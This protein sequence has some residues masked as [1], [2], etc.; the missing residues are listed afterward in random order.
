MTKSLYKIKDIW[1]SQVRYLRRSWSVPVFKEGHR[2]SWFLEP[3]LPFVQWVLLLRPS[4]GAPF[5]CSISSWVPNCPTVG[6]SPNFCVMPS[7]IVGPGVLN[8]C[9]V[10]EPRTCLSRTQTGW[11]LA[12]LCCNFAVECASVVRCSGA[13]RSLAFVRCDCVCL[14]L[15]S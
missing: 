10:R 6:V 13:G 5:R 4:L 8:A 11:V 9:Y 14:L 1:C 7:G 3:H 12:W 2:S 15:F